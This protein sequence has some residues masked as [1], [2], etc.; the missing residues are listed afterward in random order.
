MKDLIDKIKTERERMQL[1]QVDFAK[2]LGLQYP[3][4][5]NY[6]QGKTEPKAS[7]LFMILRKLG[8]KKIDL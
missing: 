2:F 4:Y 3:S 1:N 6:E 7:T 5:R 8:F